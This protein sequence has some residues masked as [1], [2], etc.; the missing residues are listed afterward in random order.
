MLR[1]TQPPIPLRVRRGW[2]GTRNLGT[3]I[4]WGIISTAFG[5]ACIA[6]VPRLAVLVALAWVSYGV[7]LLTGDPLL[8]GAGQLAEESANEASWPVAK[9]GLGNVEKCE[10]EGQGECCPTGADRHP[11]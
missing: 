5:S 7:H 11:Y 6:A 4:R 10:I 2:S 1:R 3:G 9:S 8:M